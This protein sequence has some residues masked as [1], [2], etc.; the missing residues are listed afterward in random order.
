MT[1]MALTRIFLFSFLA[2]SG[3]TALA[4]V[5]LIEQVRQGGRMDLPVNGMSMSEVEAAYGTPLEQRAAVGNPPISRGV[6]DRWSVYFE[7]DMSLYTVLHE[8]EAIEGISEPI[9]EEV[10]APADGASGEE[11]ADQ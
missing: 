7:Y 4:D 2:L 10:D 9:V 6:Y 11:S 8:G 3:T 5:L 1:R